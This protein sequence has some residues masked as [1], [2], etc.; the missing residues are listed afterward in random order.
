MHEADPILRLPSAFSA[1]F[2]FLICALICFV[3]FGTT[4]RAEAIGQKHAALK[5]HT[6]RPVTVADAI[7]MTQFGDRGYTNGISAK[8]NVANFSPNGERYVIVVKKGNLEKNTTDYSLIDFG[9]DVAFQSAAPDVLASLSSSSNRPAIGDVMWLDDHHVTFLG[10]H[11]GEKQQ[12]YEV[13]CD[14]KQLRKLTNHATNLISYA[15]ATNRSLIFYTA[16]KPAEMVSSRTSQREGVVVESQQLPDLISGKSR[17]YSETIQDLFMKQ[18][19]VENEVLVRTSGKIAGSPLW[20]SPNGRYLILKTAPD[21][22][23]D[24]WMDYEDRK[25]QLGLREK[26]SAGT[27]MLIFRY[28]LIDVTSLRCRI[29]LNAPIRAWYSR[30]IWSPNSRSVVVSGTYLPLDVPDASERNARQSSLFVAEIRIQGG[31]VIPITPGGLKLLRWNSRTNKL[32]LESAGEDVSADL[33]GKVIGYQETPTGWKKIEPTMADLSDGYH[34]EVT[35]EE[36][37]NTPPRVFARDLKSGK[38][39]LLLDLNPQFDHLQFGHVEDVTFKAT[40]GRGVK[41][42]LYCPPSY[43]PGKRYPLVI[44]THGW[45]PERFWIDGPFS[46]AFAAQPL[47]SRGF[48]VV[49]L[50]EDF[51]KTSTPEEAPEEMAAYEGVINYLDGLGLIDRSRVGIIGFSRSGFTVKYTLTHS[52]YPFAAA[53]I[54][55]GSDEGYFQYLATLNTFPAS[56]ADAEAVNGGHPFWE[57]PLSWL[58]SSTG[59][60]LG[61]VVTPVR[62]EANGAGSLLYSWEWFAGL[63]RLGKPVDFIYL[64]DATHILV[65]PWDRMISQEGNVDW[66]RFW[67]RDEED[68]D[69]AKAEQ[70][71]RWRELRQ[72]QQQNSTKPR[73][74]SAPVNY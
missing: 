70:Y 15:M 50:D 18:I 54:A 27:L 33:E 49:Q 22:F 19:G 36:D 72:L 66:F 57:D 63:R 41:A 6:K 48:F 69:P 24:S 38:K 13:D 68:P 40:D 56:A 30:V 51:T 64:P 1:I 42:G 47:A 31:E 16:E 3:A 37:L 34:L 53:T 62:L 43:V 59:F 46:T 23:P 73:P 9:S 74:I 21:Q 5:E 20:L 8:H 12:L 67:L 28:E 58:K 4:D 7:R 60:G 71:K 61:R 65:K 25:L 14:T 39:S 2:H 10:E 26:S 35:L 17:F 29:L 52:R 32:L 11:P 45:N 55:D 44:Q